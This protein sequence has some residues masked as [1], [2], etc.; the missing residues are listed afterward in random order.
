MAKQW[1]PGV[2][3]R[4]M[5]VERDGGFRGAYNNILFLDM[6]DGYMDVLFITFLYVL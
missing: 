1:L 6:D 5:T 4:I 3:G 2:G